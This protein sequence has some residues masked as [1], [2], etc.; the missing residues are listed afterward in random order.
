V[1]PRHHRL[2]RS[3]QFDLAVRHGRRHGRRHL[4]VHLYTGEDAPRPTL[5]GVV[6]SRAVGGSVVRHRVA[7]QLR[8]LLNARLEGMPPC[9]LLVV[10]ANPAAASADSGTLGRD[11]DAALEAAFRSVHDAQSTAMTSDD[12]AVTSDAHR[13]DSSMS[14]RMPR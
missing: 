6:V 2:R 1:V 11:L 12:R 10:R 14:S 7:R 3:A 8:H 9:G 13:Q 5:V 4:V